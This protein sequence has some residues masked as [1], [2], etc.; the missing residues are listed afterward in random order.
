MILTKNSFSVLNH[1]FNKISKKSLEERSRKKNPSKKSLEKSH[2]KVPRKKS[3]EK[4][5]WRN[6]LKKSPEE[7]PQINF[8]T[9]F[10]AAHRASV[11]GAWD[12]VSHSKLQY[13]RL[14]KY[15]QKQKTLSSPEQ[16]YILHFAMRYPLFQKISKREM[17]PVKLF[18]FFFE[19][20][21][22]RKLGSNQSSLGGKKCEFWILTKSW[23]SSSEK[24]LLLSQG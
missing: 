11:V 18:L 13:G 24:Y 17:W 5:N 14:P 10:L 7:I 1:L 4:I 9:G 15:Q 19:I 3:L 12:G 22:S 8:S 20:Y 6:P 16:N 2:E 21:I 23:N